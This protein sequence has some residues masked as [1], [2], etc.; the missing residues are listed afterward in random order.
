MNI[1]RVFL[2]LVA[3]YNWDLKQFDVKNTFLH[4]DLKEYLYRYIYLYM[5]IPPGFGGD[6]EAKKVYKLRKALYSLKQSLRAWFDRFSKV[7]LTARYI[8]S[9]EYYYLLYI[10]LQRELQLF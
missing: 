5:E 8:Q 4:G 7:I 2:S 3:N 1:V 6:L 9:Q 10:W